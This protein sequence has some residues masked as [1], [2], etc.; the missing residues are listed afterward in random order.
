MVFMHANMASPESLSQILGRYFEVLQEFPARM[1]VKRFLDEAMP[2]SSM[3]TTQ[4][5]ALTEV[6]LQAWDPQEETNPIPTEFEDLGLGFNLE[7][8]VRATLVQIAR[9]FLLAN[10]LPALLFA[11]P[12]F[13][14]FAYVFLS[15]LNA[16]QI[17][18]PN[19][20]EDISF[21]SRQRYEFEFREVLEVP[22]VTNALAITRAIDELMKR[23]RSQVEAS[24]PNVVKRGKPRTNEEMLTEC[25]VERFIL[26]RKWSEIA[27]TRADEADGGIDQNLLGREVRKLRTQLLAIDALPENRS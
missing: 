26:R 8:D 25:L 5:Q 17:Y 18:L 6:R 2:G 3:S 4:F 20:P 10:D 9:A 1:A 27:A 11:G 13:S 19:D 21:H 24:V 23:I 15:E 14:V 12:T 7:A 22:D 16:A